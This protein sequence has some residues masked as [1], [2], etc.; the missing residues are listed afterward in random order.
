MVVFFLE[1]EIFFWS[2]FRHHFSHF[3]HFFT[4]SLWSERLVLF[5]GD[6]MDHFCIFQIF[7][8]FEIIFFCKIC[9][10]TLGDTVSEHISDLFF[11]PT[12][13]TTSTSHLACA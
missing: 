9:G 8:P 1:V 2:F 12:K 5:F 13:T 4:E 10:F 3:A 7:H 6:K 11:C